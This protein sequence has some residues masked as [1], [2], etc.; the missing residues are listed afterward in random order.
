MDVIYPVRPGDDNEELRYSL[1]AL[2]AN[3]PHDRV[4]VVG[5]K[6]VWVTGCEY[7]PGNTGEYHANVYN[8]IRSAVD[9]PDVSDDVVIF[10]DDFFVTEPV[11]R[12]A[13]YC[14]GTMAEHIALPRVQRNKGWWHESLTTTLTC[15]HAN[16]IAEPL[17]YELHVPLPVDK[18]RMADTLARFQYVT[19]DNPPQWRSLYGNLHAPAAERHHDVKSYGAGELHRPFHSTEDR[20][21]VAFEQQIHELFPTPSRYERFA[22]SR[23]HAA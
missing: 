9:H 6:P 22:A 12:V 13:T 23:A 10:N 15:L 5:Y 3:F 14:R 21:F 7:I 16:G 19:P 17:S 20:S 11:A 18:N 2:D 4:W 1:R 8:N